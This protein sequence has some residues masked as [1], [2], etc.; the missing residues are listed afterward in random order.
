MRKIKNPHSAEGLGELFVEPG[1]DAL[2]HVARRF[3][4]AQQFRVR[5][6]LVIFRIRLFL[7]FLQFN[8][9]ILPLLIF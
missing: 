9:L 5:L 2:L 8:K 4:V 6:Q 1:A 7:R 3:G